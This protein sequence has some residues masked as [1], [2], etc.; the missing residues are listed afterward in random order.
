M[1]LVLVP[2]DRAYTARLP[3]TPAPHA[4]PRA[5]L[6]RAVGVCPT[7]P[8]LSSG[9]VSH[10]AAA[11]WPTCA[12][13]CALCVPVRC[14]P[15]CMCGFDTRCAP[16]RMCGFDTA[17][18][19]LQAASHPARN[20]RDRYVRLPGSRAP[21]RPAPRPARRGQPSPPPRTEQPRAG[22]PT[23]ASAPWVVAAGRGGEAGRRGV[24]AGHSGVAGR[25]GGARRLGVAA[26]SGGGAGAEGGGGL[27]LGAGSDG[28]SSL[29]KAAPR[30][31]PSCNSNPPR[32]GPPRSLLLC[33]GFG[34]HGEAAL[35]RSA[36]ES[37]RQ[38]MTGNI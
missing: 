19:S 27:G 21:V 18:P 24:A 36:Q 15:P 30:P 25:R 28:R 20:Q 23:S 6:G 22:A 31:P 10:M 35:C 4:C 16:P 3:R 26:R 9:A 7:A 12:P 1:E 38:H 34:M 11:M 17:S 8:A 2:P 13:L 32:R 5:G 14:A 29:T 33:R 37:D